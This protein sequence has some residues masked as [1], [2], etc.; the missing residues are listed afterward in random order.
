MDVFS[1]LPGIFHYSGG[2]GRSYWHMAC[3]KPM[4]SPLDQVSTG[5]PNWSAATPKAETQPPWKE[6]EKMKEETTSFKRN[7][8]RETR[9]D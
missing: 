3:L 8:I 2:G 5:N 7:S 4:H 9:T 1:V 6:R